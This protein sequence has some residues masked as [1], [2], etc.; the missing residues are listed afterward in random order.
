MLVSNSL[1]TKIG[2]LFPKM[3][4]LALTDVATAYTSKEVKNL[5]NYKML[6]LSVG[7]HSQVLASTFFT[8]SMINTSIDQNTSC[9][10]IYA[11]DSANYTANVYF[12]AALNLV[13][14]KT[15]SQFDCAYLYGVSV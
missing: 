7:T 2:N 13:F 5:K 6:I 9:Q 8:I 12:N 1:N 3:D 11:L 14:I 15:T 4:L 10:C